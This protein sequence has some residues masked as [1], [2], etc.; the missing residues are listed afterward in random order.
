MESTIAFFKQNADLLPPR[1]PTSAKADITA[2]GQPGPEK[3]TTE[4][5]AA[6][7]P[8]EI[9]QQAVE[10]IEIQLEE[11]ELGSP[12][13]QDPVQQRF[14]QF[15]AREKANKENSGP[16]SSSGFRKPATSFI[17]RQDDAKRVDWESQLPVL[18][19][20][21]AVLSGN[22]GKRTTRVD[23]EERD[24]YAEVSQDVG[25]EHDDRQI[26]VAA[27]RRAL[28]ARQRHRRNK[29]G[30]ASPKRA[31]LQV[32]PELEAGPEQ[33]EDERQASRPNRAVAQQA[34]SPNPRAQRRQSSSSRPPQ[35]PRP[36]PAS[37]YTQVR[38]TAREKAAVNR[39]A[40]VQHR[41]RWT[42]E[43]ENALIDYI[44]RLGCSWA[45]IKREDGRWKA[46]RAGEADFNGPGFLMNRDQ[47][48]LKDKARNMRFDYM[49]SGMTLPPNF[50]CVTL[51]S[52]Q[53]Q[54]LADMG[55]DV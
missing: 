43:E 26:D 10:S 7:E 47:V 42:E 16:R 14:R 2:L 50:E 17:D 22:R 19:R 21:S 13:T 31:R 54:K 1:D 46:D 9:E 55:I 35:S 52:A 8:V 5:A 53:R 6:P 32:P 34:G 30:Q 20:S 29:V 45:Q 37:N 25:F 48:A 49:K 23:E 3:R 11:P 38:A 51:S 12:S 40:K 39:P 27:R 41:V 24:E 33:V 18:P 15:K 4:I 28:P 44:E 36:P